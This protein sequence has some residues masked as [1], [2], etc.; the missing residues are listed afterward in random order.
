VEGHF[1]S[2]A[3]EAT[4][5]VHAALQRLAAG[6][7]RVPGWWAAGFDLLLTPTV[8]QP[9]RPAGAPL[10]ALAET[11]GLFTLPFSY[12]GQPAASLPVHRAPDGLPVGVHLVAADGREDLLLRVAAQLEQ[13]LP[14]AGARPLLHAST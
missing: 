3:L 2:E 8:A 12:T 4:D 11:T 10:T 7:G 6:V 9:P 1:K 13:A 14:W 5:R